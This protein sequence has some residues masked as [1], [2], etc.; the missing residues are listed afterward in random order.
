[1]GVSAR[2]FVIDSWFKIKC[3][4]LRGSGM[5]VR[6]SGLSY[7]VQCYEVRVKFRVPRLAAR[8]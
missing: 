2:D 5:G 7:A 6:V 8:H 1:M 3:S 4:G